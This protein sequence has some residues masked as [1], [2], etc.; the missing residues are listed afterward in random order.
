MK[1]CIIPPHATNAVISRIKE[2]KKENETKLLI[3]NDTKCN[4][5]M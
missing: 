2:K 5:K 1:K 3:L 4:I